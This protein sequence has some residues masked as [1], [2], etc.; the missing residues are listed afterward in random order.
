MNLVEPP[1]LVASMKS[2]Q[3]QECVSLQRCSQ[4]HPGMGPWSSAP[5][6]KNFA[7]KKR[8][9]EEEPFDVGHRPV[10]HV[11]LLTPCSKACLPWAAWSH[12]L[13]GHACQW[14]SFFMCSEV[15]WCCPCFSKGPYLL[16]KGY[17][18]I[19]CVPW[20]ERRVHTGNAGLKPQ[21]GS[22]VMALRIHETVLAS[23]QSVWYFPY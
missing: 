6:K 15:Q 22:G 14:W 17:R 7:R 1:D 3:G 23:F 10:F 12:P 2:R 19:V 5:H 13:E 9:R 18:W 21:S 4:Q 16:G 11:G 8:G 20:P